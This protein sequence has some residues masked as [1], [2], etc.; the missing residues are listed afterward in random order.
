MTRC[1]VHQSIGYHSSSVVLCFI[2]KRTPQM[3]SFVRSA[4]QFHCLFSNPTHSFHWV[5]ETLLLSGL[6][7]GM[8]LAVIELSAGTQRP[9]FSKP[10][11]ADGRG[12]MA[13]KRNIFNFRGRSYYAFGRIFSNIVNFLS[14][15]RRWILAN[16]STTGVGVSG[17]WRGSLV[18]S[19]SRIGRVVP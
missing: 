7:S 17:A 15:E 4:T 6:T 13:P 3:I 11:A 2:S 9:L 5:L 1:K 16:Q 19:F 12:G 10:V 8:S 14:G 18:Q